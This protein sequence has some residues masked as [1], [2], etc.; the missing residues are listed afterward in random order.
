MDFKSFIKLLNIRDDVAQGKINPGEVLQQLPE[1]QFKL[2][3]WSVADL[4]KVMKKEAERRGI[5]E[6]MTKKRDV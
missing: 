2:A 6:A 5:W 1:E 4:F 3:F